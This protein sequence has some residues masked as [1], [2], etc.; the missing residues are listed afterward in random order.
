MNRIRMFSIHKALTRLNR[1]L[2][3]CAALAGVIMMLGTSLDVFLKYAF[4][5]PIENTTEIISYYLMV[6]I[7]FLPM[8]AVELRHEN[9]SADL[10]VQILPT[11]VRN[12][13]YVAAS[14]IAGAFVLI[15]VYQTT[16]D[17]IKSTKNFE[18]QM[19]SQPVYI[20]PSKWFLPFGFAFLAISM[21][22]NAWSC[23]RNLESFS[24][25]N[26]DEEE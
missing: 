1:P 11:K 13:I 10:L 6:A 26:E 5:H 12:L 9:I 17:A 16:I 21:F 2:E 23:W 4:N 22:G 25:T 3:F 7:V 15:F 14:I 8:G 20:W 19:G 24:P 18:L